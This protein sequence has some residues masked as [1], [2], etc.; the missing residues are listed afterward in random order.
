MIG[1]PGNDANGQDAGA[2]YLFLGSASGVPPGDLSEA[3]AIFLGD[4]E[5]DLAGSAVEEA[6]DVNGDGLA[7]FLVGAPFHNGAGAAYL[8]LGTVSGLPSM[9]L[10]DANAK[11]IGEATLDG[12]GDSLSAGDVNGDGYDDLL[13]GAD[14]ESTTGYGAGAAYLVLGASF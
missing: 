9:I 7:D 10:T 14:D 3:D 5:D 11:I 8:V 13:L 12:V 2:A 1:A 6:G 4:A